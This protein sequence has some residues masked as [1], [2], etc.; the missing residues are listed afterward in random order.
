MIRMQNIAHWIWRA[1][2]PYIILI[3]ILVALFFTRGGKPPE[4]EHHESALLQ[5]AKRTSVD[6]APQSEDSA[7]ATSENQQTLS[8]PVPH[9]SR[10]AKALRPVATATDSPPIPGASRWVK[11][12]PF[13]EI[14][15]KA[16]RAKSQKGALDK[17]DSLVAHPVAGA[18]KSLLM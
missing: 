2:P 15:W 8:P 4:S 17:T 5:V 6:A 10:F 12:E 13:R 14:H 1:E 16:K 9:S 11:T 3:I 7:V 18:S